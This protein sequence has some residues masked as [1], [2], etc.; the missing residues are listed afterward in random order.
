MSD[1]TNE[2]TD[3]ILSIM[4]GYYL[5]S[6][7]HSGDLVVVDEV[8]CTMGKFADRIE[9]AIKREATL[10]ERI[11]RDAIID[12]QDMY[13]YAPNN[14]AEEELIERA[15][16]ANNW[17]VRHGYAPEPVYFGGAAPST[18]SNESEAK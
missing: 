8:E 18:P 15:A 13:A 2:S 7:L 11:V 9:A 17:L 10:I 6:P 3:D 1:E 4:R 5:S 14:E 16:R 12:Y